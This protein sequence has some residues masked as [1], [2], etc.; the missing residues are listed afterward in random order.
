MDNLGAESGGGGRGKRQS[1]KLVPVLLAEDEENDVLLLNRA[2]KEADIQNPLRIVRD[3]QAAIDYLSGAGEFGDRTRFP[4][5]CLIILD[6]KMPLIT[7]MD[8]LRWIREQPNLRCVP[9]IMLTSSAEPQDVERAYELGVNA[10][11]S[12]PSGISK[13]A[14][15]AK[16]IKGFWLGF[17]EPP[18]VCTGR[19]RTQD[20]V[21]GR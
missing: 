6:L 11:V 9:V 5:P 1:M 2:F 3:G 18:A 10:F 7:G 17:N 16:L 21:T 13:R 12:K 15:L 4:L 14:E 20:L 8:V 19:H